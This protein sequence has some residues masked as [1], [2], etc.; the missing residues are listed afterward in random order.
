MYIYINIYQ[1]MY[2]VQD[3]LGILKHSIA[4]VVSK[5]IGFTN[6]RFIMQL[7]SCSVR[8]VCQTLRTRYDI[9]QDS[10]VH[11]RKSRRLVND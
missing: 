1:N 6:T 11:L 4:G 7:I 2:A 10:S 3:C 5:Y 9:R 8:H